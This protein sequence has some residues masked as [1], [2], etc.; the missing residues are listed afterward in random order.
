[1]GKIAQEYTS[2]KILEFIKE[3]KDI[4]GF[5]FSVAKGKIKGYRALKINGKNSDIDDVSEDLWEVG[6]TYV[7]PP[8]NGIQMS[9]QSSNA[10]DTAAGTGARKVEIH[11]LDNNYIERDEEITLNGLASV[12]TV[13]T[14]ILRVNGIHSVSAGSNGSP[15]G[16]ITLTN[17][18]VTVTYTR[19]TAGSNTHK[20]AIFTVPL[21]KDFFVLAWGTGSGTPAGSRFVQFSLLATAHDDEGI[22]EVSDGLF[23]LWDETSSQDNDIFKKYAIPIYF[24]EKSDVKISAISDAA[25]ANASCSTLLGGIL[26]DN[27]LI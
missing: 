7:Y 8:A 12:L 3:P 9:V 20:Q 5:Y 16:N 26:I 23:H 15:V 17:V 13:A 27:N 14:N 10:N 6:G 2:E 4:F 1:M 22:I 24:P 19:L 25:A 18:A 21:G 11:Y